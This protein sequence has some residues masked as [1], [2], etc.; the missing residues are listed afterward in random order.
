[1]NPKE[2][3]KE[4]RTTPNGKNNKKPIKQVT[5]KMKVNIWTVVFGILLV[6]FFLPPL[7]SMLGI[8]G[9]DLK[10]DLSQALVDL[11]EEKVEKVS[12]EKNNL[13][14]TYNDKTTK[15]ATKEE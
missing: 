7:F 2:E 9:T 6:L 3:K 14:L 8:G 1:M 13:I 12:I 11:K 5:V 10:I 4:V 15:L